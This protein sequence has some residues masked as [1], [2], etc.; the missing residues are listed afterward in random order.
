MRGWLV[1][2]VGEAVGWA[3]IDVEG[4]FVLAVLGETVTCTTG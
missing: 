1:G 2:V 3:I 4:P